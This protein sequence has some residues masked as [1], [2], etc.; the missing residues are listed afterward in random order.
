MRLD[1]DFIRQLLFVFEEKLD[2]KTN[3]TYKNIEDWILDV[4]K[5]KLFYHVKYLADANYIQITDFS[6][7]TGSSYIIDLTPKGHEFLNNI[8]DK[9]IWSKTKE[10]IGP[11]GSV[12]ISAVSEVAASIIKAKL[13]LGD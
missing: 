12:A 7:S 9:N 13:N 1:Y 10:A 3:F 11:F 2:G 4:D 5:G 8:R 6:F